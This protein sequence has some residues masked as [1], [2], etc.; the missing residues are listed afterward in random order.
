[1]VVL[2]SGEE[3][4]VYV[5]GLQDGGGT[6]PVDDNWPGLDETGTVAIDELDR[7]STST[8]PAGRYTFELTGDG[9]A[10]LYVRVGLAP[11]LDAYDCRPYRNG[12][13]ETCTLDLGSP[14]TIHVMVHG[15]A[16]S[17]SYALSGRAT[18]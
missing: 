15:Y 5:P 13:E 12:S 17:S 7:F 14:A 18:P 9:D 4:N 11:Q 2:V 1:Q 8:L 6:D 3:D 10:D 16:A